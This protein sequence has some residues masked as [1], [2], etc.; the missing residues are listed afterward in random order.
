M[1]NTVGTVSS[2]ALRVPF[3]GLALLLLLRLLGG[4]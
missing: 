1:D 2:N 4:E 3:L